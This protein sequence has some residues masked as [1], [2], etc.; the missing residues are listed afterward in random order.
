M[1]KWLP[2]L[3]AAL[4]LTALSALVYGY[5][6]GINPNHMQV[7]PFIEKIR[8]PSLFPNDYFVDTLKR[9]PSVY[10]YIMAFLSKFVDLEKLHLILYVIFKSALLLLAYGLGLFLFKSRATAFVSMFLFAFSPLVNAYGLLGHD[11]LMKTSFY[12]TSAAAPL[13]LA[14]M[15]AFLKKRYVIACAILAAIYY[16]NALIGNFLLILFLA[17]SCSGVIPARKAILPVILFAALMIPGL[18]WVIHINSIYPA[19]AADNFPLLLKLWYPGHY[20][21][22]YFPFRIWYDLALA[23]AFLAVF[24]YR[25]IK[26][27]RESTVIKAFLIAIALMWAFAGIS[28]QLIPVRGFILMQFLRSDVLLIALGMIFAA[29]YVRSLSEG[30]SVRR[31][32]IGG[33]IVLALIEFSK[34]SYAEFILVAL[35]LTELKDRIPTKII[36]FAW[37]SYGSFLAVFSAA[38]LYLYKASPKMYCMLIFSLLLIMPEKRTLPRRL[39]NAAVAAVLLIAVLSFT[40]IFEFRAISRNYSNIFDKRNADWKKLSLWAA[41]NTQKESLFIAPLDMNGWRVFS[42]RAVFTDWV[43]GSAMH[44]SPGFESAWFERLSRLGINEYLVKGREAALCG[45]GDSS[46]KPLHKLIYDN[47]NED[48]FARIGRD[49]GADYVIEDVDKKLYFKN[50]YENSTFRVYRI[51]K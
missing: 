15:L 46:R 45:L 11:P 31:V 35:L 26:T 41:G 8:D 18:L 23:G 24:F 21:P 10:P 49:Y 38:S 39:K 4:I 5:E 14:A 43:D 40:H 25:G 29:D 13:A 33:L 47:L 2:A 17:A 30:P 34:P 9:F 28:A 1:K 3:A 37:I 20:F 7:L 22:A 19:R 42:K 6:Y 12:Q 16:V 36:D 51:E 27:C 44:W 48:D 50:V 32:A